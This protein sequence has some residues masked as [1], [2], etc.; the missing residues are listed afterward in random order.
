[1]MSLRMT[2]KATV[3]QKEQISIVI[4]QTGE[5]V[6]RN[7]V[8]GYK[9]GSGEQQLFVEGNPVDTV[10]I[11]HVLLSDTSLKIH[12]LILVEQ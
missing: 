9:D 6:E 11:R 2:D 5:S 4:V 1:M 10:V 12:P 8:H 7:A 3:R